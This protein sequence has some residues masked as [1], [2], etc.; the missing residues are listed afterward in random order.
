[1]GDPTSPDGAG[2]TA[3]AVRLDLEGPVAVITNDNPDRHNAFD[4]EMDR[5]LFGILDELSRRDDVRAVV[6]RGR[7]PSFSSGR[8]VAAVEGMQLD[9]THH[10]LMRRVHEGTRRILELDPPIIVALHGWVIGA[11]LQRALLCDIRIAAPDTRLRLPEVRYGVI[12]DAGGVARLHQMCGPG[13]ASDLVL[14][15]RAMDAE[16][17][18]G[19]G[20]VSRLV[21][22]DELDDAAREIAERVTAA[23]AVT[24]RSARR[25]ISHL[26]T[27]QVRSSM[28]E[29]MILQ[30]F[31]NASHDFRE[32]RRAR[33]EQR[34][35]HYQGT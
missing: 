30:T 11:S 24:V 1:M 5:Q 3:G 15:G 33:R 10:Q 20:V 17:A 8:D 6:W 2:S 26:A 23:P 7:G 12:P 32:M 25:V 18:L 29:E 9:L 21:P 31:I 19:H 13:V 4:D 28:E 16:E 22:D 27:P 14:T 34:T 35:P